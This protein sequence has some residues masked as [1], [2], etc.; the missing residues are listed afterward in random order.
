MLY[1][2]SPA[3]SFITALGIVGLCFTSSYY[4]YKDT[5]IQATYYKGE[6]FETEF[7]KDIVTNIYL[8]TDA[9]PFKG[10]PSNRFS[11]KYSGFLI[12]P[13]SESVEI[14]T[15]SD[16]GVEVWVNGDKII[17]DWNRQA[18]KENTATVNLHQGANALL[19]HYFDNTGSAKLDML[20]KLEASSHFRRIPT[21]ALK[22]EQ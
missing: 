19:V 1:L 2:T 3:K 4:D 11:I 15:I 8:S 6:N 21:R 12:S 17:S 20:W 14:R 18:K 9:S 22:H 10:L 13:E 16:D 7:A 5:G